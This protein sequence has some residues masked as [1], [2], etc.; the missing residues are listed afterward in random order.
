[1]REVPL[2]RIHIRDLHAQCIIGIYPEERVRKQAVVINLTM[3]T[4]LSKAG[5]SDEIGDTV[6]YKALKKEILRAVEA[7]SF[8]LIERLAEHIATIVL[9]YGVERV[10]VTVDKPGALRFAR[11]VAV[12]V[13]RGRQV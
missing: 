6:D 10:D 11:S 7:S 4:D 8:Q 12:E 5:R 9:G 2:D 3:Y 13:S 1:M